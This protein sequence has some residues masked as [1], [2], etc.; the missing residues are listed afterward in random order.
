MVTLYGVHLA[1]MNSA[2][3]MAPDTVGA[4]ILALDL[5][6][7]SINLVPVACDCTPSGDYDEF[8]LPRKAGPKKVDPATPD[9]RKTVHR[10]DQRVYRTDTP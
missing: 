7:V 8:A 9:K 4:W 1:S 2:P 5:I 3:Y 6:S 10:K